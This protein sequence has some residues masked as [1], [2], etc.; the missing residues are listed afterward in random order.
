[1]GFRAGDANVTRYVQNGPTNKIDPAGMDSAG[2]LASGGAYLATAAAMAAKLGEAAK[3]MAIAAG[4]ALAAMTAAEAAAAVVA[5]GELVIL[6][7]EMQQL[8]IAWHDRQEA[9]QTGMWLDQQIAQARAALALQAWANANSIQDALKAKKQQI[10]MMA[11]S[12]ANSQR[13]MQLDPNN[14][15]WKKLM[16]E[17]GKRMREMQAQQQ[18]LEEL[19]KEMQQGEGGGGQSP[20]QTGPQPK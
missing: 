15:L 16:K 3:D 5:A 7:Y 2:A 1:M 8:Y 6:G 9:I 11:I 10:A 18:E 19:L 13:M 17:L 4:E 12:A 20:G 14:P